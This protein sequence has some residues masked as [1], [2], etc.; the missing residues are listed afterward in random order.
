MY[1]R[2]YVCSPNDPNSTTL[3]RTED[4]R[5]GLTP[6]Q[7]IIIDGMYSSSYDEQLVGFLSRVITI[8][9]HSFQKDSTELHT[10]LR[11]KLQLRIILLKY[12]Q[13][14]TYVCDV[15]KVAGRR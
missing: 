2:T 3:N 13:I 10:Y 12:M 11:L 8:L 5:Q 6:D 1:I 7:N 14:I 4:R 15:S 9:H